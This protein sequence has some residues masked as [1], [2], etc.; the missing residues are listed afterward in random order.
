M[1]RIARVIEPALGYRHE[2]PQ[3]SDKPSVAEAMSNAACDLAEALGAKALLVPTFSGR[4]ASTVAQ[5]AAS[6]PD[7]RAHAPAR[8]RP[9]PRDRVGRDAGGDPRGRATSTTS[10]RARWTA[11]AARGIVEHG[12]PRRDHRRDRREH[13][14]H[15]RT[16]SRS[17][18]RNEGPR[19]RVPRTVR[20]GIP[21]S[22]DA[23]PAAAPA[24]A[25]RA[26][27]AGR[28]RARARRLPLLPAAH[29]LLRDARARC[30][31][32]P[33]EVRALRAQHAGAPAAARADDERAALARE[34]R[35]L[36]FVQPGERLFIVKGIERWQRERTATA[37]QH[38]RLRSRAW[39]TGASSRGSS[40][41]RRAPSAR[42]AVRCPFG[43]PAV[44]EQAPYDDGGEPFPT[45]YW[46]TCRHLVAA[47]SRLEAAGGVERWSERGGRRSGA[48]REPRAGDA[49]AAR[50]AA[51]ARGGRRRA[52]RRRLARRSASAAR[53][54]ERL[55]CLHA[56]AAF[57][58]ARPGY[59]LGE[60]ILAEVEPLWP[61][62]LLHALT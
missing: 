10:G 17:S 42:V 39:T 54:P 36:G 55:K 12:R 53:G 4:T 33:A 40:A 56:H 19:R 18:S 38:P 43:R 50:A 13:A 3:P 61:E 59:E 48:A 47:V 29:E 16:S 57:A 32:A 27:P 14:R 6:P 46:L 30:A 7:H 31:S 44:T 5:A 26:A 45:T 23:Q 25:A 49:R 37:E 41:G 15:R 34:A 1:D 11:R 21:P 52:R 8:R 62:T 20:R 9:P 60:R 22:A 28:R 24:A 58:L 2:L 35:Q 51:R